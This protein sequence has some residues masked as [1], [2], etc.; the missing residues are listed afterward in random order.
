MPEINN[1]NQN[2]PNIQKPSGQAPVSGQRTWLIVGVVFI[3]VVAAVAFLVSKNY[4][5][6][7]A[8]EQP[9][10]TQENLV[11]STPVPGASPPALKTVSGEKEANVLRSYFKKVSPDNFK[12]EFMAS[13]PAVA[14]NSYNDYLR[15]DFPE[16][17][18]QSARDFYIFL[19]NPA[20]PKDPS[21]KSFLADVK[22][23]LE[24]SLGKA[25]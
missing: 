21:Y 4:V 16:G 3:L 7:P 14:Y 15:A 25:L 2:L 18:L 9:V 5:A 12:E 6:K 22:A 19:T 17:K 13:V 8:K 23:D 10:Q 20:A 1:P 24:K 11:V